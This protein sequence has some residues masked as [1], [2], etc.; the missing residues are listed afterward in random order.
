MQIIDLTNN[1]GHLHSAIKTCIDFLDRNGGAEIEIGRHNIEDSNIFVNV[2]EYVTRQV[3]NSIWE[4][5]KE[6]ADL[7][8]ILAGEEQV[9]VS[10][11]E[12][13]SVGVYHQD[14]DYLECTGECEKSVKLDKNKCILLLPED[15][16][17]PGVCIDKQVK[18]V[19]KAVFKIP[20]NL[21]V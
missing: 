1:M 13:M 15:V 19:K 6:Y 7:Q 5:H 20:M 11:I 14:S 8:I 10:N 3:E 21:L 12:T 16:H 18:G 4:A 2:S 9:F 17:M